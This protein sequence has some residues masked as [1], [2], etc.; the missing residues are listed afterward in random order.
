MVRVCMHASW[1]RK[2]CG[3][4]RCD[5]GSLWDLLHTPLLPLAQT[6]KV[7]VVASQVPSVVLMGIVGK[8]NADAYCVYT[9]CWHREQVRLRVDV[10]LMLRWLLDAAQ[11]MAYLHAQR[12]AGTV[13]QCIHNVAMLSHPLQNHN[14][15]RFLHVQVRAPRSKEC[16]HAGGPWAES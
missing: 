11:G 6:V 10:Q 5:R 1:L 2:A 13:V 9:N 16:Q 12:F 15:L 7:R 8:V 4:N 14:S 3:G